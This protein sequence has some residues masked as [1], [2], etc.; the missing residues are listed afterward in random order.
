[1]I[2]FVIIGVLAVAVAWLG[3]ERL[4]HN[5]VSARSGPDAAQATALDSIA[6][7]PFVNLSGDSENEYFGDGLAEELLNVLVRI[8]GLRVTA[9]TSSFQYK[10]QNL[11]IR[12]IGK[13]LGVATV[14]EGSVRKAGERIR[15]T[16]QLIRAADGFHLWSETYDRKLSDIF[17]VQDEISLAIADA[18]RITLGRATDL[19]VR[20]T[21]NVQAFEAYLRGRFAMNQRT[22]DSLNR[23]IA[24][25]RSAIELDPD[26][27]AA[28]SGLSDSYLLLSTYGDLPASESIQ[29]AEP[30]VRRAL[31]LDPE[32]AEAQASL[33]L[34]LRDKG[35]KEA[36]IGALE[37]A[38]ALNPSYS[39]AHHWLALSFQDLGR[40]REARSALEAGLKVDPAYLTGK[41]VLLGLLRASGDHAA[42]DTLAAELAREHSDDA[43]VQYGL[44]SDAFGRNR[45]VDA[46]RHAVESVRLDPNS[47]FL[48]MQLATILGFAGDLERADAQMA[49]AQS[50][51]PNQIWSQLWP[52][53]RAIYANDLALLERGRDE[54]LAKVENLDN[55][56]VL[57]CS[58]ASTSGNA[59]VIIDSC[60]GLLERLDWQVNTPLPV[61]LGPMVIALLYAYSAD[62]QDERA[63]ALRQAADKELQRLEAEGLGAD[64]LRW[65][66]ALLEY[67]DDRE[68]GRFVEA[69]RRWLPHVPVAVQ[70]LKTD[71]TYTALRERPDF[72]AL[73]AQMERER[74][75]ALAQI[76][77]VE[78]PPE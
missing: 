50:Q 54:V 73:I 59:G 32:L 14:L 3:W 36:S 39:P 19:S 26:Y 10:G 74:A 62:G 47:A 17:A 2:D 11:D 43:L 33:G 29:L 58:F 38:I 65:F 8:D 52:L 72:Q 21:D 75:E 77:Q 35:D 13:A 27:A 23:A 15:V 6:V 45:V 42:A 64:E 4:H 67:Y 12:E 70:S 37:K 9:R 46:L 78:L 34:M 7:L 24:E 51:A 76:Q 57:D 40:L 56:R 18:L 16:A 30:M 22:A 49:I 5:P 28:Y 60:G 55:R 48:R 1:V 31:A 66:R 41:R 53:Q 71:L 63:D 68:P 20:H 25:F 69:L 44:A 61:G